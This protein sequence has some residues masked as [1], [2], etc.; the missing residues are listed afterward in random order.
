MPTKYKLTYFNGRGRAELSRMI[1]NVAGIK[2]EDERIEFA[3]WPG[4]KQGW[5]FFTLTFL[6]LLN[7]LFVGLPDYPTSDY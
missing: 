3:D 6:V 7:I 1:F 4:R 2:F 5:W